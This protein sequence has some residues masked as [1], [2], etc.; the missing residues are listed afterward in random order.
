M[1]YI[2]SD[3]MVGNYVLGA[4]RATDCGPG[5]H[6]K[7]VCHCRRLPPDGWRP[8]VVTGGDYSV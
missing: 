3:I 7:L 2:Y 5:L 8:L 4:G 1:L 6:S